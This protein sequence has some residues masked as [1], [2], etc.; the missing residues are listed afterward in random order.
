MKLQRKI[1]IALASV[2]VIAAGIVFAFWPAGGNYR[3]QTV[4]NEDLPY[5]P[6]AN[7]AEATPPANEPMPQELP[8]PTPRRSE[9]GELTILAPPDG[10]RVE[11]GT[12]ITG[13]A[14]TYDNAFHV[15]IKSVQKGQ[16]GQFTIPLRD[17]TRQAQSFTFELAFEKDP[18]AGD[19]GIVEVYTLKAGVKADSAILNVVFQ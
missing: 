4:E 7:E 10:E 8:E 12:T 13:R 16:L 3:R 1:F 6:K 14:K 18:V 2:L 11:Q 19:K 9:T 17:S 15:L 5:L